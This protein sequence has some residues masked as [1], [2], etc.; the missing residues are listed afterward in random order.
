[1]IYF[2]SAAS[3]PILDEA[4]EVLV[5]DFKNH[6]ANPSSSHLLGE[7]ALTRVE[8]TREKIADVLGA[9]PSE[10]VF[11]SGATESNNLALKGHFSLPETAERRHLVISSI[12]HKCVHSIADYLYRTANVKVTTIQ[13]NSKGVITPEA[14]SKAVTDETSLISVMHLNNELGTANPLQEIGDFC[15]E[16]NIKFHSDAAQ[17]FLKLPIDVEDMNLDYLSISAHKIGGPKGVGAVYLRDRRLRDF[18]PVIHGAGQEDG[19]RGGTLPAPLVSSFGKALDCFPNAYEKLKQLRL[20]EHLLAEL[21]R[22]CVEFIVNGESIDSI[23]S[24]TLPGTDVPGLIRQQFNTLALATGSACSSKEIEASHVLTAI[25]LNRDL[26][27]A[28]LRISFHHGQNLE[29]IEALANA[30]TN[31]YTPKM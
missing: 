31:A 24:L 8:E 21:K 20:K 17:S 11:T 7:S 3:Y 23:V 18:E 13:P 6:Q 30:I 15:F 25:G 12:E 27:E 9:L 22:R 10:I 2:D 28:T 29:D 5:R 19:L 14:V 1:M 26:A 16:R 4:L